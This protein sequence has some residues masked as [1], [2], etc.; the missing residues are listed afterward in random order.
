MEFLDRQVLGVIRLTLAKS[1][2]HNVVKERPT[3]VLELVDLVD[4]SLC[5]LRW[6]RR[7]CFD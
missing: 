6:K 7:D 3:V 2:A 1:I 4:D 5:E